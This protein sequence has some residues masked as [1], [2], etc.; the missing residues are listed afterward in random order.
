MRVLCPEGTRMAPGMGTP[1]TKR[2]PG[3]RCFPAAVQWERAGGEGLN[4]ELETL[5]SEATKTLRLM[6]RFSS[7]SH[8][9]ER[10]V[11][12]AVDFFVKAVSK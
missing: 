11:F 6:Q 1:R 9:A 12:L 3:T 10:V 2:E 4:T 5:N 7:V 8:D